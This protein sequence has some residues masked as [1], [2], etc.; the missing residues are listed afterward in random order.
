MLTLGGEEMLDVREAATLADRTPETVRR[1]IWS[2][3]LPA[4]K[5]GHRLL[6]R[7][8]DLEG[9]IT[10]PRETERLDLAGW[11]RLVSAA[12]SAGQLGQGATS[13]ADLILADRRGR[14]AG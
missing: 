14:Q 2:G 11:S 4:T 7:R 8:S 6:I 5:H 1:W 10:S 13:A 12:R 3:R 9:A